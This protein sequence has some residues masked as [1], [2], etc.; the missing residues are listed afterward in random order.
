LSFAELKAKRNE[1]FRKYAELKVK[2]NEL[3]K[4]YMECHFLKMIEDDVYNHIQKRLRRRIAQVEAL[5][6]A[7]NRRI[8]RSSKI[9]MFL[10][11]ERNE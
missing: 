2:R 6:I 9:W 10:R 5:R 7:L 1:V 4:K 3:N 11:K 8:K